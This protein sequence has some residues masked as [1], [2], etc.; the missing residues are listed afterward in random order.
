[1][2][3][4]SLTID[5]KQ[6]S[7]NEGVTLLQAT[8]T[9]GIYVPTL[10]NHP[11]LPPSGE[12]GLCTVEVGSTTVP[13]CETRAENGMVVHTNTEQVK[14]IRRN[15]LAVIMLH[16]PHACLTCAQKVGCSRTQCSSNVAVNERCCEQLG[17]CEIERLVDYVGLRVDLGRYLYQDL[18]KFSNEPLFTRDYNL[19]IGCQRCV[20][21]C[22]DLRGCDALETYT[23]DGRTLVKA[24]QES[25]I[26]SSCKFCTACVE[27]CPTG[28]LVDK[29][30]KGGV[31]AS[32]LVP[33]QNRCPAGINVPRYIGY[34]AKEK[35]AEALAVVREQV[36][37]PASLGRVCFH[38]CEDVCR[39][40]KLNAPVAICRVKRFASDNGGND[41]KAKR[42]IA[43]AT[44][45]K[46]AVIGSG[47]AGLTAAN[48]LALKGHGVTVFEA[49]PK[50]GGMLRVGIPDYR[51][52]QA[53]LD[54]EIAEIKET[55]V[56][57]KLGV[58]V[59]SLDD[60][61]TEGYQA[62]F[63]AVGAH[64]G[65]NLGVPGE[66]SAGVIVGIRYLRQVSLKE[67]Y[68]LGSRVAV[69]GG[70]NVAMDAARSA[71]RLGA[72]Q[73]T[74]L[75]RRTR[76]EM[77]A[78]EDEISEAIFEGVK[79][80]YL[81]MPV[82]ISTRKLL[83]GQSLRVECQRMELGEADS[84]GRRRPIPVVGS[85]FILEFDNLI[86][87]I[88]QVPEVPQGFELSINR[89][90]IQVSSDTLA[91]NK[92]GVYAGGDAVLGPASVIE[93]IA[94]G[95]KAAIAI[96]RYLGGDGDI[97]EVLLDYEEASP[98]IGQEENFATAKRA[99][100]AKRPWQKSAQSS[101]SSGM[102]SGSKCDP[103][104]LLYT[105]FTE[106][107]LGMFEEMAVE[108]AAR[109]LNC[110]LRL[111]IREVPKP[112][113]KWLVF[114]AESVAR[115]PDVEG[116][117]QLLNAE[118]SVTHIVGTANIH[119]GLVEH[120]DNENVCFFGFEKNLM[121]T[122]RESQL[123]QQ[124]LQENGKLPEGNDELNDLF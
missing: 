10:C 53:I 65:I 121:Y 70:G 3:T 113:D 116:V 7:V 25:L 114:N 60:L 35:N 86:T 20:R 17:N 29:D 59:D 78:F 1:M 102:S 81:T 63:V 13:A 98:W 74:V 24:K 41:W 109:C 19:C 9:A 104:E 34:V 45:K 85:E 122:Q 39:R 123:I 71:V 16:H 12:C 91:T 46:V 84:T 58:K 105:A 75:Y 26:E 83:N 61:F 72:E 36:P 95:R 62:V 119:E 97:N 48:Y 89:T 8:Q 5:G 31:K 67:K 28:A 100:L 103:D 110:Q 38:P 77:P 108:E 112:P 80:E 55:G 56:E 15:K 118:K 47:P 106:V 54:K 107:E 21:A 94:H 115:V 52:P 73:V 64:K 111:Q 68:Q 4:I 6:I 87:A 66:E 117:F 32:N 120:L 99:G 50:A 82:K 22:R 2:N 90:V 51:L 124:F 101:C 11:D 43:S 14:S 96:D 37:F 93:A 27:V 23:I 18:P 69:V 76:E 42:K 88:G 57:I 33:C 40:G 30:F 79:F 49:L 92:Q 44:N